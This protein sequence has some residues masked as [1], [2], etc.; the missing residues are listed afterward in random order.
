MISKWKSMKI[1]GFP[2]EDGKVV[3]HIFLSEQTKFWGENLQKC[4]ETAD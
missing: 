3:E 4:F 2:G 1:S